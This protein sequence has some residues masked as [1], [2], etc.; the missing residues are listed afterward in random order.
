MRYKSIH[1]KLSGLFI[2]KFELGAVNSIYPL[3]K[4]NLDADSGIDMTS[5]IN[6]LNLFH[7]LTNLHTLIFCRKDN[8]SQ[9]RKLPFANKIK[10]ILL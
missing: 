2:V 9:R 3:K 1:Y 7:L 5:Q 10:S 6:E 4:N 8:C